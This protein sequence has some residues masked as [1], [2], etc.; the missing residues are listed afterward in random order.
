MK[1]AFATW[2]LKTSAITHSVTSS[3]V[4]EAGH[5]PS[6]LPDGQMIGLSGQDPVPANLSA[7][8]DNVKVLTMN[9]TSGPRSSGLSPPASL[10]QSLANK[11]QAKT[12]SR[13]STLYALTW[14][15]RAT[16]LGRRI[17]ALRASARRTS[18]SGCGGWPTPQSRDHFPAHSETYVAA[19]KAQCHGMQNLNDFAALAGWPTPEAEEA[20]RGY[21]NRS[22]GKK[23]SQE[24]MTTVVVNSLGDKPH[25][26]PHSPARL[27]AA[28]DL[29]TGSGAGMSDGGQLNP[30]HSRWLMGYPEEWDA[31]APTVTP[32]SRKSRRNS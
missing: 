18:D 27:T 15:D 32:S 9:D 24:S 2:I 12:A 4:L 16:P 20:R 29:L 23:G 6:D 11:L 13:G 3:P 31:C 21:Q 7:Q 8:Q 14:K 25:L 1:E 30:A 26:Q 5:T 10:Q 28:G 17:C 19:K 22:N